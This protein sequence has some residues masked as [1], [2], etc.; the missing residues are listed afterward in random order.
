[1]KKIWSHS[2]C[3]GVKMVYNTKLKIAHKYGRTVLDSYDLTNP[4]S[5]MNTSKGWHTDFHDNPVRSAVICMRV[6]TVFNQDTLIDKF[7]QCLNNIHIVRKRINKK[8]I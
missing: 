1:M 5:A 4:D 8:I 6:W 7:D 2:S 3:V